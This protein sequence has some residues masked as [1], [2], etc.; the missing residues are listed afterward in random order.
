M[1][2]YVR[3]TAHPPRG[4]YEYVLYRPPLYKYPTVCRVEGIRSIPLV[5]LVPV[6]GELHEEAVALLKR[7]KITLK[8]LPGEE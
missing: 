2:K 4:G 8:D 1:P 6:K 3:E 5:Y 7:C